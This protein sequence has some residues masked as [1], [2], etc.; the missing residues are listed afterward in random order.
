MQWERRRHVSYLPRLYQ[1]E[2][3]GTIVWRASLQNPDG[4]ERQDFAA[5][6][7]LLNFLEEEYG[8]VGRA[9]NGLEGSAE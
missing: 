4:S 2:R 7:D 1:A 5:L 3:D 6:A 8:T 9:E